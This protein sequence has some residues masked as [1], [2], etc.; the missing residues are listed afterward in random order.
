MCF[1]GKRRGGMR[2]NFGMYIWGCAPGLFRP[3]NPRGNKKVNKKGMRQ[4]MRRIYIYT[5]KTIKNRGGMRQGM[6][7][8]N[9]YIYTKN[10]LFL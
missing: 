2:R 9:I 5:R 8:I 1:M 6:R 4:G 3:L 7:R 10:H